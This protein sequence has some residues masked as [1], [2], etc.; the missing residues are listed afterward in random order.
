MSTTSS[1]LSTTTTT[2]WCDYNDTFVNIDEWL[3]TYAEDGGETF[4]L[5]SGTGKLDLPDSV[6]SRIDIRH[7][8]LI[9]SGNGTIT[10]DLTD[11]Q[12]D[13]ADGPHFAL[14]IRDNISGNAQDLSLINIYYSD[15]ASSYQ[16]ECRWKVNGGWTVDSPANIS[17]PSKI[18]WERDGTVIKYHYYDG[19]WHQAGSMD[20]GAYAS[21]LATTNCYLEDVGSRG[22]SV[23]FDNLTFVDVCPT[24]TKAWTTTTTTTTMSTTTTTE[25]PP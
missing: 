20:Y 19:S 24:G 16:H 17:L 3:V 5:D 15:S 10:I 7:H 4:T 9:A 18:R 6:S 12:K 21:N 25:P 2:Y 23:N 8:W 14:Y 11:Y 1:T 22:G 13:G